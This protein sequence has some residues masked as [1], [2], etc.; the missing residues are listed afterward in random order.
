MVSYNRRDC[1]FII[2]ACILDKPIYI[3]QRFAG[4][5]M[6]YT[7]YIFYIH[8]V[9]VLPI[10][11]KFVQ[12]MHVLHQIQGKIIVFCYNVYDNT[13]FNINKYMC[14]ITHIYL[15]KVRFPSSSFSTYPLIYSHESNF[16]LDGEKPPWLR[17]F[18]F[19]EIND[20]TLLHRERVANR[21]LLKYIDEIWKSSSQNLCNK[22][23]LRLTHTSMLGC[24]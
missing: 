19:V 22:F 1:N 18:K 4:M 15:Y 13:W 7:V 12:L 3:E 23:K 16:N 14:M 6:K 20:P 5:C 10:R 8:N 11:F 9:N 2:S 21:K 17:G 24:C